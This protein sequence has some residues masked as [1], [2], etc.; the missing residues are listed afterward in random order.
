MLRRK[1]NESGT[2]KHHNVIKRVGAEKSVRHCLVGRKTRKEGTGKHA[3][4]LS[5]LE[6][7]HK[8]D[9]RGLGEMGTMGKCLRGGL[10]VA[11]RHYVV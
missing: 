8:P 10:E 5:V 4:Q 1:T 11:R 9:S 3:V 2:E 6:G 7:S